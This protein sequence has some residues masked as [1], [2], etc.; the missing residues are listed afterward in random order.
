MAIMGGSNKVIIDRKE[1]G[2]FVL[3]T[4]LK[5]NENGEAYSAKDLLSLCKDQQGIEQNFGFLKDPAIV[6]SIFLKMPERIEV[7]GMILLIALRIW[8]LMERSMR[9]HLKATG[10]TV[11]GWNKRRTDQSTSYMM[12]TKIH[13]VLV[14]KV[15]NTRKLA[16]PLTP[17]HIEYLEALGVGPGIF[18]M[19]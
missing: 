7:L 17:V 10:K 3:I 18:T 11:N 1:G 4:N 16:R 12:T 13:T 15:G 19:T 5:N 9:R 2:C 6:D 14:V 8:R